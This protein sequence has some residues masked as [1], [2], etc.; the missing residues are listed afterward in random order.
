MANGTLAVSQLEILTQSGT[1]IITVVPP[2]TNTNRTLT[3]P[4]ITATVITDSAGILNIGSGQVYKDASGNVGIGTSSP[5]SGNGNVNRIIQVA[6]SGNTSATV[7]A[8]TAGTG[9]D[10]AG[11]FEARATAQS[12]GTDRL[13]QI[14]FGRDNTSTTALSAYMGFSTAANGTFAER[15][16]IDSSGN[17]LVGTTSNLGGRLMVSADSTGAVYPAVLN[18]SAGG[19]ANQVLVEFRRT[20]GQVGTISSTNTTAAY[21]TASDYRLKEDVQP[22][23]GALDRVAALKPCTYKWKVD[24]SDGQGFI[25]HE[26]AE[27]EAGCVTG[28]KDAVD[29]E[30]NPQYQGIDTSF[31]VATLTAAIQE[32]QTLIVQ[33]QADIAALKS[34]QA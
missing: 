18:N 8:S 7:I 22:M 2:A 4:D 21:N 20:S 23:Q 5:T 12:S 25:A 24:G 13:G 30:G 26:L 1:G 16:R 11:I 6:A 28:E 14:Y 10:N 34:A 33:L 15:A 32:Q 19:T 17:L 29:A 9:L 31:L 27:V 3:L